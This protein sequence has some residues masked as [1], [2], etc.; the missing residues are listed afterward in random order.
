MDGTT[1]TLTV[2]SALVGLFLGVVLGLN[3]FAQPA[4][5]GTIGQS[6]RVKN[7]MWLFSGL[8]V[9]VFVADSKKLNLP[10][11]FEWYYPFA[12]YGIAAIVGAVIAVVG[13]AISITIS[14]RRSP[15]RL[16]VRR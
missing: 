9:P 14:V 3:G 6:P 1:T 8:F 4:T 12:A 2:L 15:S 16:P 13:M 10:D 5:I 11:N 7:L